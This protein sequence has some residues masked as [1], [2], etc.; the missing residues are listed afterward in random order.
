MKSIAVNKLMDM[1]IRFIKGQKVEKYDFYTL[2][3][4]IKLAKSGE[5]IK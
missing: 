1:G 5:V 2:C 3:Y 4:Y